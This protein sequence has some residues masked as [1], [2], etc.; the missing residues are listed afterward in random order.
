MRKQAGLASKPGP[1]CIQHEVRHSLEVDQSVLICNDEASS[2]LGEREQ[3]RA[4]CSRMS[5][6][7]LG[8]P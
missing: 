1:G 5:Y 3:A 8:T 2:R 6:K 7:W 4:A